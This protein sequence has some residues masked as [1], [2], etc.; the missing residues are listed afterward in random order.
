M[1]TDWRIFNSDLYTLNCLPI[2]H[3]R[4]IVL[5]TIQ[6]EGSKYITDAED[7]LKRLG[8]KDPILKDYRGSLALVGYAGDATPSWIS[9]VQRNSGEGPSEISVRIPLSPGA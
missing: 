6:D 2:C 4:K 9:L 1:K 7:A 5:V 3:C 8:A